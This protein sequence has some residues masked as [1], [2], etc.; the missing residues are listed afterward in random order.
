MLA[1]ILHEPVA[2]CSQKDSEV[3][4]AFE[5]IGHEYLIIRKTSFIEFA[6][7]QL[8]HVAGLRENSPV[9]HS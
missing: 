9:M 6:N 4:V 2:G 5:R 3:T 8:R 1:F 7:M